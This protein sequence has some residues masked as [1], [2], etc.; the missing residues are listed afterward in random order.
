MKH[1]FQIQNKNLVF[2][3]LRTWTKPVL[4][5]AFYQVTLN[6]SNGELKEILSSKTAIKP[7]SLKQFFIIRGR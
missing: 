5:T 1:S 3:F 7:F 2:A 4:K 6:R